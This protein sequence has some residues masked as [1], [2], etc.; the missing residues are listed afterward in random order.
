M[1]TLKFASPPTQNL[2]FNAKPQRESVEYRLRK[3]TK[4]K[5]FALTMFIV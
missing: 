2:K 5:T 1:Q 3:G 4:R